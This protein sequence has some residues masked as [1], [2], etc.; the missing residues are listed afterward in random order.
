MYFIPTVTLTIQVFPELKFGEQEVLDALQ[1][2]SWWDG[3]ESKPA[4]SVLYLPEKSGTQGEGTNHRNFG[5]D[6]VFEVTFPV[7]LCDRFGQ[8]KAFRK[9]SQNLVYA[10]D[11]HR[12]PGVVLISSK[13]RLENDCTSTYTKESVELFGVYKYLQTQAA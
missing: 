2:R 4:D 10:E 3:S 1:E 12:L 7:R 13:L 5:I 8:T 9:F 11:L 6:H